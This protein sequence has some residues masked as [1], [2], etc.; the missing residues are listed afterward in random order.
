[1]EALGDAGF[2]QVLMAI[3]KEFNLQSLIAYYP[4]LAVVSH[5]TYTHMHSNPSFPRVF[6]LMFSAIQ[7]DKLSLELIL[8][9]DN[10][11]LHVPYMYEHDQ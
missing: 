5:A 2:D 9:T 6:K 10:L 4:F 7:V 1:M 11:S 3:G 8:G